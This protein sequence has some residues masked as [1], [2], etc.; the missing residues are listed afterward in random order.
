MK[1]FVGVWL[2]FLVFPRG[3]LSLES[4]KIRECTTSAKIDLQLI[5]D[6]SG[7]IGEEYFN[8]MIQ[9]IATKLIPQLDI[10]KDKTRV[11]TFVYH[12]KMH[13]EFLLDNHTDVS[14]LTE[15]IKAIKYREGGKTYTATAMRAALKEYKAKVRQDSARVCVVITD[16]NCNEDNCGK[17]NSL[18]IPAA[19]GL[20]EKA[21]VTLFAVGFNRG[22]TL[23]GMKKISGSRDR[24]VVQFFPGYRK[25]DKKRE[26]FDWFL[27]AAFGKELLTKVCDETP[28]LN[29]TECEKNPCIH[30]SCQNEINDFSCK[31][32]PGYSGKKCDEDID[33]CAPNPCQHGSCLDKVNGYTCECSPGYEG[34]NCDEDIDDCAPNPCQH[35]SC[36]DM[37]NDYDCECN[38][39]YKGKNCDEAIDDCAS[40]PCQHGSC[41]N[42]DNG[43]ICECSPGYTG[44]NCDKDIDECAPN[45]CQHGSCLNLVN[46]YNCECSPGYKGKNCDEDIDLCAPNPCQHGSCLDLTYDYDCECNPG[47]KGKDCDEDIDDCAN[48]PCKNGGTCQDEIDDYVCNC[49]RGYSGKNCEVQHPCDQQNRGGCNQ[50]CQK[51]GTRAICGCKENYEL[52]TDKRTCLRK[53]RCVSKYDYAPCYKGKRVGCDKNKCWKD[54]TKYPAKTWLG[55]TYVEVKWSYMKDTIWCTNDQECIDK[56]AASKKGKPCEF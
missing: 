46:D 39:G 15:A 42:E 48:G 13:S 23:K 50:I 37:V 53:K 49:R 26:D 56:G 47:Y 33:E 52:D 9:A 10:G 25:K 14:S 35:G 16:G 36:L 32:E 51:D 28:E 22:T 41:F 30:G 6:T 29:I 12:H 21:G 20:W 17:K 7:S 2:V 1:I 38:P 5:I 11:G 3:D 19:R 55:D 54:C 24:V 44:D 31:C 34:T 43:Y 8:E 4:E 18:D 27:K 45:P 40:N